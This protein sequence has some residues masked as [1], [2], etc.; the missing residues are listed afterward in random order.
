[1]RSDERFRLFLVLVGGSALAGLGLWRGAVWAMVAGAVVAFLGGAL[2]L[3]APLRRRRELAKPFSDAW[4]S[5]LKEQVR[6]Y[7]RLDAAGKE[8]FETHLHA[9]MV[10]Y[11][12]QAVPPATLDDEVRVLALSGAAILIHGMPPG[13][14]RATRDV[15]IYPDH[16]DDEYDLGSNAPI[17]GMVHRQGPILFSL[18]ALREGW[19]KS[20]GYNVS[21]H[22]FAHVLDLADGFADGVPGM[23]GDAWDPLIE[24]ALERVRGRRSRLRAYAGTN[25]AELFAVAVE[26]FFET[27]RAL[28]KAHGELYDTLVRFFGFDPEEHAMTTR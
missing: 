14:L 2:V 10:E 1:M 21:I 6:F 18:K 28:Q 19:R 25:R 11:R 3:R 26:A 20:N 23:D 15:V 12:F 9:L 27:P 16:F 8:R 4:R 24:E 5:V 13:V 7:R 17:A 22:E